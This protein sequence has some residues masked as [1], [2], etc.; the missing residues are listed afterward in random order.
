MPKPQRKKRSKLNFS[1]LDKHKREGKKLI[2]PFLQI[3]KMQP[4]SWQGDRLPEMLWAALL[5]TAL[6]RKDALAAFCRAAD[7]I[8]KLP[9]SERYS[10]VSFSGLATL[11][12]PVRARFIDALI[13]ED[14]RVAAALAP[15][16]V[17]KDLPGYATWAARL[18]A[19]SPEESGQGLAE[20]VVKTL[21]H[22][23]Q[24]STDCRWIRVLAMVLAGRLHMPS[25]E[26]HRELIEYPDFGDMRK[27]RPMIRACEISMPLAKTS[28]PATFWRV[29]MESTPC[30][31]LSLKRSSALPKRTFTA[32]A[33]AT[34]WT[35]LW[36]HFHATRKTT[37]VDARHETVFAFGFYALL[38]AGEMMRSRTQASI[39]ARLVLRS[40]VECRITLAYLLKLD[41]PELWR[42]Y[43]AFGSGQAKLMFL[44]LQEGTLPAHVSIEDLEMLANE[45]SWME[46]VPIDVGH[47]EKSN[48]REMSIK[49]D[50]KDVYDRYYTWTSTFSHGHWSA[51]RIAV[52]D[53]CSNPLHRLHRIPKTRI[54]SFQNVAPDVADQVDAILQG[55]TLAFP[56]KQFSFSSEV[57]VSEGDETSNVE[58][59][60]TPESVGGPENLD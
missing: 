45:D 4:A 53:V 50:L 26:T 39:L 30:R 42:S 15:L 49:A 37:A 8:F 57:G 44:K 29:C 46:F 32:D 2:P 43:R 10:D 56:G 31:R 16:L 38:L 21:D 33:F 35:D 14:S 51:T 9:Q 5:V 41:D 20:A 54:P 7:Q 25:R 60:P 36:E 27:V 11:D 12:E 23:S 34:S 47:W 22:Q 3:Q 1:P 52:Y 13:G 17:L 24:E 59:S 18:S 6:D 19:K 55:V 48:L 40:I 58:T 28:W